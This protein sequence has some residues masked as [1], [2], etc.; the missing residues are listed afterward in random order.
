[1]L[2]HI[3]SKSSQS[4][5]VIKMLSVI[6]IALLLNLSPI[7]CTLPTSDS[8]NSDSYV[9]NRHK[10]YNPDKPIP[11]LPERDI[12]LRGI[13]M[14]WYSNTQR[15]RMILNNGSEV[16]EDITPYWFKMGFD[17]DILREDLDAMA[18]MG[19]RHIRTTALI[20]QFL[21]WKSGS[22]STGVNSTVISSFN[23]FLE[24]VKIRGMVL[25]VSFLA[26]LWA[27]S[28]HPSLMEYFQIF[29]RTSGLSS[30]ALDEQWF[31]GID[32]GSLRN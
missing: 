18:A 12:L 26:P 25:T 11:P 23:T 9:A 4:Q 22:G 30:S 16:Y 1:M 19:V 21:N 31:V 20:F 32:Q 14:P 10:L 15:A 27:Y 3:R 24:E 17:I 13:N 28:T 5:N 6:L 29:N 8:S 7:I 2:Q